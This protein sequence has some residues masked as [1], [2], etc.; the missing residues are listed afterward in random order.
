VSLLAFSPDGR[1]LATDDSFEDVDIW[2]VTRPAQPAYSA[3][4][5][6]H[7]G[8]IT[9][10]AFSPDGKDLASGAT[11]KTTMISSVADLIASRDAAANPGAQ[12]GITAVPLGGDA[13]FGLITT[14]AG[15]TGQVDAIAYSPSGTTLATSGDDGLTILWRV[16]DLA[17]VAA[18]PLAEACAIAGEPTSDQW[19]D[20]FPN[21]P[22]PRRLCR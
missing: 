8:M 19:A 7:D 10:L 22:Y 3:T 11:D 5:V 17:A 2:N 21:V 16:T 12:G 15:E 13:Q 20:V 4:F 18:S 6:G 14:L 1:E 9:A